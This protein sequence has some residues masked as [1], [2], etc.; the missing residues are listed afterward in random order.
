MQCN[1]MTRPTHSS[2]DSQGHDH[3]NGHGVTQQG[4][5]ASFP[6]PGVVTSSPFLPTQWVCSG[7]LEVWFITVLIDGEKG[8]PIPQGAGKLTPSGYFRYFLQLTIFWQVVTA[9]S[10]KKGGYPTTISYRIAPTAHKN[11]SS[12]VSRIFDC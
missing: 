6:R 9:S 4:F 12:L 2:P 3:Q 8:S 7:N 5:D 1:A 11:S 10:E